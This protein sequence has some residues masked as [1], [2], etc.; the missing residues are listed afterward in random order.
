MDRRKFL[1][2][3][4]LGTALI[5]IPLAIVSAAKDES[6]KEVMDKLSIKDGKLYIEGGLIT[7]DDVIIGERKD[8]KHL[9]HITPNKIYQTE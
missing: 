5:T 9:I 6:K 7:N 4:G 1:R 2:K 8:G 3:F